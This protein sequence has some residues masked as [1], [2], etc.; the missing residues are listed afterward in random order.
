M[1]LGDLLSRFA[2]L[3][4]LAMCVMVAM[5]VSQHCKLN[6]FYILVVTT[7]YQCTQFQAHSNPDGRFKG[8]VSRYEMV[9]LKV[10]KIK[11]D[12]SEYAPM[13]FQFFCCLIIEKW[14]IK[15]QLASLKTLTN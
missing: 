3:H 9:Y 14:K 13:V 7:V 6:K 10:F 12:L 11:S 8:T 4:C 15:S 1:D 5:V 2:I